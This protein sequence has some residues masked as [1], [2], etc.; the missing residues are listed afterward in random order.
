M[1]PGQ[2]Q[3]HN[4]YIA[5]KAL[6][7]VRGF[8]GRD[9]ILRVVQDALSSAHQS[10][11]VLAG[12][13]RIGKTSILLQLQRRLPKERFCP[14]YFDLMDR[15]EEPLP[16]VL[17]GIASAL[18]AE[19]GVNVPEFVIDEEGA[20]FQQKFLP[21]FYAALGPER[22]P[23]LLLDEFDVLDSAAQRR[24]EPHSAA[25]VFF[26][27]LRRL[28]EQDDRLGFVF[29]VGRKPDELSIQFKAAF[30]TA[31]FKRVSV[32]ERDDARRL[33]LTAEREGTLQFQAAAVERILSLTAGH[34]LFTQLMC[35]ILWDRSHSDSPSAV[36]EITVAAV[37]GVVE[38]TLEAGENVFQWIWDGLPPAE[39]IVSAATAR[40]TQDHQ[41]VS[42]EEL[43]VTLQGH[44]IR[45]LTRE[46]N[47][48]PETLVEW[49]VLR[50]VDGGYQFFIEL[51]R[52][53]IQSRKPL[54]KVKSELDRIVQPAEELY[55]AAESIYRQ[56]DHTG[57][58][59]LLQQVLRINPN[60][61]NARLLLGALFMEQDRFEEAIGILEQAFQYD[62]DNA[63]YP[64]VRALLARGAGQEA[65][66]Q[67]DLALQS[68][69]RALQLSPRERNAGERRTAI[70]M[71]RGER[72]LASGDFEAARTAFGDAGAADAMDRVE[73]ARRRQRVR[74]LESKLF[75]LR[76]R[77]L[78]ATAIP[79]LDELVSL[80]PESEW[81]S[82]RPEL[83]KQIAVE[84]G[85][86][87]GVGALATGDYDRAVRALADVVHLQPDY[88]DAAMKLWLA[89]GKSKSASRPAAVPQPRFQSPLWGLALAG[90]VL[91]LLILMWYG[92]TVGGR[93]PPVAASPPAWDDG[94]PVTMSENQSIS[95][96]ASPIVQ[97]NTGKAGNVSALFI[98][99]SVL[100]GGDDGIVRLWNWAS[101]QVFFQ[102]DHKHPIRSLAVDRDGGR[103]ITLAGDNTVRVFAKSNVCFGHCA[104]EIQHIAI[105][106]PVEAAALSPDG[107]TVAAW[108]TASVALFD[109]ETASPLAKGNAYIGSPGTTL[110]LSFNAE[111]ALLAVADLTIDFFAVPG[112]GKQDYLQSVHA[113]AITWAPTEPVVALRG[114][115]PGNKVAIWPIRQTAPENV[116]ETS[117]SVNAF[118]FSPDSKLLAVGTDNALIIFDRTKR[119]QIFRLTPGRVVSVDFSPNQSSV[120]AGGSD[121][122]VRIFSI[123]KGS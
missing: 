50:R 14:V 11:I 66:G 36:P 57:V 49:E 72:S 96:P 45:I 4:P 64:L 98:Q 106:G 111:G 88:K 54:P 83:E 60:H 102:R 17:T 71:K 100:T 9:D 46:L 95:S 44:G 101:N 18:A 86:A 5:G 62:E 119:Q 51:M 3:G 23:V 33:I 123:S 19:S 21:Q 8:V 76:Q 58:Q 82:I 32:L 15:A 65:S 90:A 20:V 80:D 67:E 73:A 42:E 55:R 6:G 59:D 104:S 29:V 12:Q 91:G 40:A 110:P 70:L 120:A 13:R 75:D 114:Y 10:A 26:P 53:W 47:I 112:L 68:Y 108:A 2:V 87:E 115:Y 84:R 7:S 35:Q 89:V 25:L 92:A 22:R 118:A 97:L 99:G 34:P 78:D 24:L 1:A 93:T 81:K 74:E 103:F 94:A 85:Y 43:L 69:D 77:G 37:D 61:V 117:K 48:A 31:L 107:K 39:R 122:I 27:Y 52:L 121:G 109:T 41:I 38:R 105:A 116:I 56:S 16:R 63:R 30:K 113:T 28:M 79:L